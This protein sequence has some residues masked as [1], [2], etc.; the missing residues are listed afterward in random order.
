MDIFISESSVGEEHS[1]V[2][3]NGVINAILVSFT[4]LPKFYSS[5]IP[6]DNNLNIA[7]DTFITPSNVGAVRISSL[8]ADE[9][10]ELLGLHDNN[11]VKVIMDLYKSLGSVN[12]FLGQ[13]G[14]EPTGDIM[15]SLLYYHFLAEGIKEENL[16][17][18]P[19]TDMGYTYDK[20]AFGEFYKRE[21][22]VAICISLLEEKKLMKSSYKGYRA[23]FGLEIIS[24]AVEEK[25]VVHRLSKGTNTAVILTKMLIDEK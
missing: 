10:S 11:M 12:I 17:R 22:L 25:D 4:F 6:L 2:K 24:N 7:T 3:L 13:D 8:S 20:F 16:I 1:I 5:I 23:L 19:L 18:V 15:A 9:Q 14:A 21:Q